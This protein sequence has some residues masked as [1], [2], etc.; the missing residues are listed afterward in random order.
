ME[1]EELVETRGEHGAIH[2]GVLRVALLLC[3]QEKVGAVVLGAIKNVS[4]WSWYFCYYEY[5]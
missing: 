3:L 1:V 2:S 4:E 5:R